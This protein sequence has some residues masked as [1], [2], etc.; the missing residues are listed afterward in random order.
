MVDHKIFAEWGEGFILVTCP[1]SQSFGSYCPISLSTL[2]CP[3][4][5]KEIPKLHLGDWTLTLAHGLLLSCCLPSCCSRIWPV[6][7][8]LPG[9]IHH[10]IR[11]SDE[12]RP[13]CHHAVPVGWGTFL[14]ASA[15]GSPPY[16]QVLLLLDC[17]IRIVLGKCVWRYHR[18]FWGSGVWIPRDWL[19]GVL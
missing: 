7:C 17:P 3:L 10:S 15:L 1:V 5:G 6:L 16:F 14:S 12:A 11:G 4:G 18:K 9:H 2:P 19:C 8:P 13:A